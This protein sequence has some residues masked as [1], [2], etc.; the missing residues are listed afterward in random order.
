MKM[1]G[2]NYCFV[3]RLANIFSMSLLAVFYAEF[4]SLLSYQ[5]LSQLQYQTLQTCLAVNILC[6]LTIRRAP[7]FSSILFV[8]F[9]SKLFVVFSDQMWFIDSIHLLICIT[10]EFCRYLAKC[11]QDH[12]AWGRR[13]NS[14]PELNFL[15]NKRIINS[16]KIIEPSES[17]YR[18]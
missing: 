16:Q 4:H 17:I 13:H 2:S 8:C 7:W 10:T 14:K 15:P 6:S 11:E 9:I 18:K 1:Y 12:R 3:R 5:F